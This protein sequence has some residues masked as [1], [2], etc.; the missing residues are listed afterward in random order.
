MRIRDFPLVILTALGVTLATPAIAAPNSNFTGPRIEASLGLD[1]ISHNRPSQDVNYGAAVGVDLPLGSRFTIGAEANLDN[2]AE[3]KDFGFAGRLGF[4]VNENI[5]IFG[6]A[7]YASYRNLD[8]LR[9]GGGL[10]LSLLGPVYV[11]SEYRYADIGR[12]SGL[13]A[14]G[15]RF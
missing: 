14:V 2:I 4:A 3:R 11:K 10:E 5:L 8:G 1:D 13:L 6:T 15:L 9:V 7:G 12:H